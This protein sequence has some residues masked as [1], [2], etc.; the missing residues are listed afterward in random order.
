MKGFRSHHPPSLDFSWR[1]VRKASKGES[2]DW[3]RSGGAA[4]ARWRF[5][6][7]CCRGKR[8]LTRLRAMICGVGSTEFCVWWW[9]TGAEGNDRGYV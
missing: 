1:N 6:R 4:R 9:M 3:G 8:G 2:R 5:E 7:D